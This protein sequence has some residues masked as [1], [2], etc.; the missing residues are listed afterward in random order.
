MN[1]QSSPR[2]SNSL[3][4]IATIINGIVIFAMSFALAL[5]VLGLMSV[6]QILVASS[7][8]GGSLSAFLLLRKMILN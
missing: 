1:M 3:E 6:D 4:I 8:A 5:W 7:A 2:V